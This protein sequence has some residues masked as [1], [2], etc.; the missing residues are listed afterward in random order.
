MGSVLECPTPPTAVNPLS[1]SVQSNGKKHLILDL[2]YSNAYIKKS[3]VKFEDAKAMLGLLVNPA[4]YWMFLI[5]SLGITTL[6]SMLAISSFLGLHG[7]LTQTHDILCLQ[8]YRLACP[9]AHIFLPRLSDPSV[10]IGVVKP[11]E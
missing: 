11:S 9:P 5:S 3:R 6:I 10:S 7:Y 1:V 2:R 4:Q 8:F